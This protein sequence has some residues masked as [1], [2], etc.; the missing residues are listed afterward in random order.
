M[1]FCASTKVHH[2]LLC[3]HKNASCPWPALGR[4]SGQEPTVF[5]PV[6]LGP[7]W[8]S[9]KMRP[10]LFRAPARARCRFLGLCHFGASLQAG[11]RLP[12]SGG[13]R[14]TKLCRL[15]ELGRRDVFRPRPPEDRTLRSKVIQG[16]RLFLVGLCHFQARVWTLSFLRLPICVFSLLLRACTPKNFLL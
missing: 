10:A 1:H 4:T 15:V 14:P 9:P 8:A 13:A 5:H 3:I 6:T 11:G 2:A 7:P 12:R 16:K